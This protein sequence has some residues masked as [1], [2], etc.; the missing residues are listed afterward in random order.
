V[1]KSGDTEKTVEGPEEEIGERGERLNS[2]KNEFQK[3]YYKLC[4]V[5][6]RRVKSL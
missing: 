2:K 1:M 5:P 6:A 4:A 3:W